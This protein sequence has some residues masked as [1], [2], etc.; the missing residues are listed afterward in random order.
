MDMVAQEADIIAQ[1]QALHTQQAV[2]A[3]AEEEITL[4]QI[5]LG[6]NQ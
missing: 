1:Q 2:M 4:H 6:I 5:T 3:A